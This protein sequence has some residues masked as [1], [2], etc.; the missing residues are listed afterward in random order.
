MMPWERH[1]RPPATAAA[2]AKAVCDGEVQHRHARDCNTCGSSMAIDTELPV[3]RAAY[4]HRAQLVDRSRWGLQRTM[5]ILVDLPAP[6]GPSSLQ[7]A[8]L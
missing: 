1:R 8:S 7:T 2:R 3:D 4:R 6:F 5:L